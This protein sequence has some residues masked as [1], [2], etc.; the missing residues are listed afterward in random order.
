MCSRSMLPSDWLDCLRFWRRRENRL[1]GGHC[2]R[3]VV[4]F[5]KRNEPI[6]SVTIA[7]PNWPRSGGSERMQTLTT[8]L[9]AKRVA[10]L[11]SFKTLTSW[12]PLGRT[13]QSPPWHGYPPYRPY[14]RAFQTSYADWQWTP[15]AVVPL[16]QH[17][18]VWPLE[19]FL[20]WVPEPCLQVEEDAVLLVSCGVLLVCSTRPHVIFPQWTLQQDTSAADNT[21]SITAQDFE[22]SS[23][24]HSCIWWTVWASDGRECT[25][26][27]QHAFSFRFLS[28]G[29]HFRLPVFSGYK[30]K[31]KSTAAYVGS[32]PWATSCTSLKSM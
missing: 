20:H 25:L 16:K 10:G 22:R 24:R 4:I 19:S 6:Y 2:L 30:L 12:V 28:L 17:W 3:I 14:V 1:S 11:S 23:S 8:L 29:S 9:K 13:R 7:L 32:L 15:L 31:F 27:V 18:R 21:L 26:T 5:W